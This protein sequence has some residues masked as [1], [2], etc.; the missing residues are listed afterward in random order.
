MSA[1]FGRP[2]RGSFSITPDDDADLDEMAYGLLV[3]VGGDVHVIMEDGSEDTVPLAAG[4]W[5]PMV[6][7][8][9]FATGTTATGLHG[10][11]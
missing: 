3:G 7:R 1:P 5:H 2:T 10:G 8:K 11:R 6:V 4:V 9:V